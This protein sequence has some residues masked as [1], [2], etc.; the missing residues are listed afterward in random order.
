M[1][2]L[3]EQQ[4]T[5]KMSTNIKIIHKIPKSIVEHRLRKIVWKIFQMKWN[6]F[7]SGKEIS[8]DENEKDDSKL[9]PTGTKVG[10]KGPETGCFWSYEKLGVKL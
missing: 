9:L 2:F 4:I 7:L 1:Y 8:D 10:V 3:L 5:G 6:V